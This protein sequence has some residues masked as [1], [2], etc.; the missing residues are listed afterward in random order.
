VFG[1]DFQL[2]L[3]RLAHPMVFAVN[4]CVVVNALALV[5]RAEVTL[6]TR[7]FYRGRR[8]LRLEF[9][10]GGAEHHEINPPVRGTALGCFV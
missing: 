8:R 4:E 5:F 3:A 1:F 2:F 9:E 10:R 6:H 7:S